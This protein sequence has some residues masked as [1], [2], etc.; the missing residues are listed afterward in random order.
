MVPMYSAMSV[1]AIFRFVSLIRFF[2]LLQAGGEELG[3]GVIPGV[4]SPVDAGD[5][6]V[7]IAESLLIIASILGAMIGVNE[8]IARAFVRE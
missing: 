8:R 6:T 3:D 1:I 4:S 2:F 7:R 5:Q